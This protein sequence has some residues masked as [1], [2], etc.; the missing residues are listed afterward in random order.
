MKK[1]SLES[2]FYSLLK[3][4]KREG[5]D[6]VIS[7]LKEEGFEKCPA[8]TKPGRHGAYE[9]GLLE[10][11]YNTYTLFK[12]KNER[13]SLGLE[14]DS[15]RIVALLHDACKVGS[16]TEKKL[17][18]GKKSEKQPF[19]YETNFHFGHGEKSV[20]LL[21]KQGLKL[22]DEEAMMIRWHMGAYE[23]AWT[24]FDNSD[25]VKSVAKAVTALQAAD[26]EASAYLDK[27]TE[28]DDS[29]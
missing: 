24:E 13:Y 3:E 26:Q 15:V 9:G 16:Y 22:S 7:W 6:S 8:S 25:R 11:S 4:T 5:I 1:E 20:Y 18:D 27:K 21:M 28:G 14:E 29:E 23:T 12:E 10:H 19:R 2:K 17:K